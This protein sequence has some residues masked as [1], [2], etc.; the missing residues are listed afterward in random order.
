M[1]ISL[2]KVVERY[3]KDIPEALEILKV[4]DVNVFIVSFT[5]PFLFVVETDCMIYEYRFKV[6]DILASGGL[7]NTLYDYIIALTTRHI[8]DKE[9][10]KEFDITVYQLLEIKNEILEPRLL[11]T[12]ISWRYLWTRIVADEKMVLSL[13]NL[14]DGYDRISAFKIRI[15]NYISETYPKYKDHEYVL[16]P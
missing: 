13:D 11:S 6:G 9:R 14:I 15:N 5:R 8:T 1:K 12:I 10:P 4:H 7:R 3:L 16:K 2:K